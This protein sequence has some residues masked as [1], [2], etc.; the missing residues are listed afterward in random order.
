MEELAPLIRLGVGGAAGLVH[1][2]QHEGSPRAYVGAPG[3]EVA[4]DERLEDAGL[5]AAL[6]PHDGDLRQVDR[7]AAPQLR[8]DVLQL[9]HDRDHRRPHR[10]RR[11][12]RRR[13]R[14]RRGGRV[15][16]VL[17]GSEG[18]EEGAPP[19]DLGFCAAEAATLRQ[20]EGS[21][22]REL[23][24][25]FFFFFGYRF[26]SGGVEGKERRIQRWEREEE[27]TFIT[28]PPPPPPQPSWPREQEERA[29]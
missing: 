26:E 24:R 23:S 21:L 28:P 4:A 16:A 9:V 1:E 25:E 17:H 29:A 27:L 13:R 22:D 12:G 14:R 19:L 6:A 8:E 7:G 3:Q 18:V 15:D 5:A 20:H 10:R 2:L 11:R